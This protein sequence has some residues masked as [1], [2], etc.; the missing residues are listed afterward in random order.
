MSFVPR[1]ITK[2][3]DLTFEVGP[4]KGR[5]PADN[6]VKNW[7]GTQLT[8]WIVSDPTSDTALGGVTL[9]V[10][11]VSNATFVPSFDASQVVAILA[12]ILGDVYMPGFLVIGRAAL[13]V[14]VAAALVSAADYFRRFNQPLSPRVADISIARD[15]RSDRKAG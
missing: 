11:V 15:Q 14:V 2:D 6:T 8:T 4:I 7:T 13:W 5:D 10:N 9:T 3:N 12:L 1:E